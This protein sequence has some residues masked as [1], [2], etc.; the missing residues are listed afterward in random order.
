MGGVSGPT[1]R[2]PEVA[3]FCSTQ[4]GRDGTSTP[5]ERRK[6][7]CFGEAC[8]NDRKRG[9]ASGQ[10]G[11]LA[12]AF[13]APWRPETRMRIS[14]DFRTGRRT[15]SG[16]QQRRRLREC[17]DGGDRSRASRAQVVC[18]ATR[19]SRQRN[20]FRGAPMH[21]FVGVSPDGLVGDDGFDRNQMSADE[22]L[23]AGD[24]YP[25][26]CPPAIVGR[27]KGSCGYASAI[28]SISSA[29]SAGQ[30]IAIRIEGDDNDFDRLE[31]R[32]SRSIARW[33]SALAS[34]AGHRHRPHH[35]RRGRS[36]LPFAAAAVDAIPA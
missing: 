1:T 36:L 23:P 24:E 19:T 34:A 17:R 28:G 7:Q 6:P 35:E 32:A 9:I 12:R 14:T 8:S 2:R 11:S 30:G 21:S 31:A 10:V 15:E 4:M 22:R 5:T 18:A 29:S 20:R 16:P 25:W 3:C 13:P 26:R 33:R 27:C